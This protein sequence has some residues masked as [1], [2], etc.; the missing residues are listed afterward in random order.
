MAAALGPSG[1]RND[2]NERKNASLSGQRRDGRSAPPA[3]SAL[4][5]S[6]RRLSAEDGVPIKVSHRLNQ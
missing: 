5:K 6:A 3:G 4:Q 2:G 1:P